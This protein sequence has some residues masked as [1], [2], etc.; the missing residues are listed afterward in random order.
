MPR[1][2]AYKTSVMRQSVEVR[3]NGCGSR[4]L[5]RAAY[6]AVDAALFSLM[7]ALKARPAGWLQR[8]A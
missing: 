7:I 2:M 3:I 6:A 8:L 1:E 4:L 5:L